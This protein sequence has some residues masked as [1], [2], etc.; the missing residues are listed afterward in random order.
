LVAAV[1]EAAARGSVA[2]V[3]EAAAWAVAAVGW[4]AVG[5]EELE[6]VEALGWE[7]VGGLVLELHVRDL[8]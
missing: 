7:V 6:V 8:V 2:A 5:V 1:Q 3:Q 4:V